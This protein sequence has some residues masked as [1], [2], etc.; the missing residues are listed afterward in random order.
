MKSEHHIRYSYI[1]SMNPLPL[2]LIVLN[3]RMDFLTDISFI[4]G[5]TIATNEMDMNFHPD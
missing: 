5:Q 2:N 4:P 3:D 1:I